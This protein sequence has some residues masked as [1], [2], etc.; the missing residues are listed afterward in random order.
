[1]R[2]LKF[3]H[4]EKNGLNEYHL[5]AT[6]NKWLEKTIW[7]DKHQF[8]KTLFVNYEKQESQI[9]QLF[10]NLAYYNCTHEE[11]IFIYE[12]L[13]WDL[14]QSKNVFAIIN[15]NTG[16]FLNDNDLPFD[17]VIWEY[18]IEYQSSLNHTETIFTDKGFVPAKIG[19][20]KPPTP[21]WNIED[22]DKTAVF[23]IDNFATFIK[24]IF[25]CIMDDCGS[26]NF[27]CIGKDKKLLINSLQ[28][29]DKPVLYDLLDN[30]DIFITLFL[31]A[32]EG[33]QDYLLIKS[34]TNLTCKL[35]R[36]VENVN[37]GGELY[38]SELESVNTFE[39]LTCLIEKSFGLK[40][41]HS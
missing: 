3:Q 13:I 18:E 34:K 36:I 39:Q 6:Y 20:V 21:R 37:N 2:P 26:L 10:Y 41:D 16:S 24:I 23:K 1:M 28:G 12:R 32:D 27:F 30:D 19:R 40:I 22:E 15:F 7:T 9:D 5:G 33:Y 4:I 31:G 29:T 11:N 38:E 14:I 17:K 35:N 25:A 8:Y